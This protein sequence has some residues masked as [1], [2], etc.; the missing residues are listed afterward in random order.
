M[1]KINLDVIEVM[2]RD[3]AESNVEDGNL[4]VS[5]CGNCKQIAKFVVADSAFPTDYWLCPTCAWLLE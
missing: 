3:E 4:D 5:W 2:P 1:T